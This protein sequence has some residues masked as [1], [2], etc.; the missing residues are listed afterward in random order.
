[1]S[2]P[3]CGVG[4]FISM[5]RFWLDQARRRRWSCPAAVLEATLRRRA[6]PNS[7]PLPALQKMQPFTSSARRLYHLEGLPDVQVSKSHVT[8]MIVQ[9]TRRQTRLGASQQGGQG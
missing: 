8:A 6:Q 3:S 4:G 2:A 1:M 5:P 7:A 9:L